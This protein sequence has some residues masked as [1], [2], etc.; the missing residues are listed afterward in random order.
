MMRDLRYA[1]RLIARRPG[2]SLVAVLSLA[3]GIGANTTIFSFA[4]ALLLQKPDVAQ[5]GQLV[6]VYTHDPSPSAALGGL[7]PLSYL[8]Y[9]DYRDRNQSLSGLMLY[10]PV[11]EANVGIASGSAPAALSGE[12]VSANYF[13]LLGLRPAVGR[14]FLPSEGAVKGS[15]AVVV[16]SY[17]NWQQRFA[18]DPG[19]VGRTISMNGQPFTV[20][21]VAPRGF[22]GLFTGLNVDWW[23]P[24]TM[25][26]SLGQAGLLDSRGNRSNFAV[27]RL[28]PGVTVAQAGADVNIIQQQLDKQYPDK[29]LPSFGGLATPIGALPTPFRGFVFAGVGLLTVVVGLVLLIACAN[30]A[31][32]LLVEA[33]GRRREWALRAA[34][35]ATRGRLIR[36]GLVHSILLALVAGGLGIVFARLL[37]PLLLRLKPQGFPI[38]LPASLNSGILWFTL[39]LAL[40]TGILFG[41]APAWQGARVRVLDN[42]KDGTPGAGA[43][44]SRA[45]SGFIVAQVALCVVVLVGAALC[46]RSLSHASLISPGFDS[47]HLVFARVDPQAAGHTGDDAAR[48]LEQVRQ[49]MIAL[50]GVSAASYTSQPPLQLGESDAV[51]LPAG[52]APPPNEPGYRVDYSDVGPDYFQTSGTRL[53]QGRGFHLA[54]LAPGHPRLAVVNETLARQ[55]WPKGDALGQTLRLPRSKYAVTVVGVAENGKY[56][57]LGEQ[58]RPYMYELDNINSA[59][60]LLVHVAGNPAAL[61]GSVRS[62]LQ[63][64]DPELTSDAIQTGADYMQVPLF[65]A[66]FSGI[67]L[68]GFGLLALMLA[69]VGLYGVIAAAVAQRTREYGIRMALGADAARLQRLVVGQGLRLALWGIAIGVVLAAVLTQF[70]SALLYGMSPADPVSYL[71]AAAILAVVACLASYLPARRAAHVDPLRALRWE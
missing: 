56:R 21:G 40:I 69:V 46:L 26:E 36:Q 47:Q 45:R 66:R 38:A 67:L 62:T 27:G 15:S 20:I 5:P 61:M 3:L 41:L 29:E 33:L 51:V 50:P 7:Y 39:G 70:M 13:Q 55:F 68:G 24:I 63:K 58:P 30:A 17:A 42:L 18:G 32:V 59:S 14:W 4:N 54:D 31:L 1:L 12:L 49:A 44:R 53:L 35:G 43:S 65:P 48:Y 22:D 23:S 25:A 34:L 6:E 37:Q 9:L 57:S 8:D 64:M 52:M 28:K 10:N 16:L 11:T 60:M 71:A 2:L 19:V